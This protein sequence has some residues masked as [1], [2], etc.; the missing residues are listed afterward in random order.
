MRT[1]NEKL[2]ELKRRTGATVRQYG[3]SNHFDYFATFTWERPFNALE[4]VQE[5]RK[6]IEKLFR[7][8]GHIYISVVAPNS[9]GQGW[10][11]HM[12]IGGV[13]YELQPID[14]ADY[15]DIKIKGGGACYLWGL[16]PYYHIG[17][18]VVQRIGDE[19]QEQ[20]PEQRAEEQAR[21]V[22][23][24]AENAKAAKTVLRSQKGRKR[25]RV[26]HTSK[27]LVK[28]KAARYEIM[29]GGTAWLYDNGR[30]PAAIIMPDDVTAD[31]FCRFYH[32]SDWD[33]GDSHQVRITGKLEE[34]R[35]A[36]DNYCLRK[37][38]TLPSGKSVYVRDCEAY[39]YITFRRAGNEA[40]ADFLWDYDVSVDYW[41]YEVII[42]HN[43]KEHIRGVLEY[44]EY[45]EKYP[46]LN[47]K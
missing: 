33:E 2:S 27:G 30:E 44:W 3:M 21:V 11:L 15:P 32:Y 34:L 45:I 39:S 17:Q 29:E 12:M 22:N 18:H 8:W 35:E 10:H 19:E 43:T 37:T 28:S 23:Y 16:A 46:P 5:Q 38:Y 42:Y 36:M 1:E 40:L 26:L 6:K 7:E 25:V 14:L 4:A 20:E 47:S 41:G 9:D 13:M 31:L 24:L